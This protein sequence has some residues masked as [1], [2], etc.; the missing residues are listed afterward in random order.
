[1]LPRPEEKSDIKKKLTATKAELQN[2]NRSTLTQ[3]QQSALEKSLLR[4]DMDFEESVTKAAAEIQ[5]LQESVL[6]WA[7][8]S[9]R[10]KVDLKS[11]PAYQ[12]VKALV[13]VDMTR[14]YI[15]ERKGNEV[16]LPDPLIWHEV[17]DY[18]ITL[19]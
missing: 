12:K 14:G 17:M 10:A 1:M 2:I 19:T 7:H 3:E 8:V 13:I 5:G 4:V 11:H 9:S 16:C 18:M 15:G 6:S